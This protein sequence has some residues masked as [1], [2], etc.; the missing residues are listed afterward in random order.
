MT[1]AK[2]HRIQL[3]RKKGWRMPPNTVKA[4]RSTPFG[5]PFNVSKGWIIGGEFKVQT[6]RYFVGDTCRHF[7]TKDEAMAD[8]VTCFRAYVTSKGQY[9][10]RDLIKAGLRGKNV[11]CWCKPGDPCHADVL[12]EIANS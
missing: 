10:L 4:D 7:A 11:A 8:S 6:T 12:L 3:S 5:N 2:P 1:T 9:K